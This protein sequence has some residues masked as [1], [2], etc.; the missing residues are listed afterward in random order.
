MSI[1]EVTEEP[2][3]KGFWCWDCRKFVSRFRTSF[4]QGYMA[5][6]DDDRV[7][8]RCPDCN[9]SLEEREDETL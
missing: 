5:N 3:L 2:Q 8:Y 7:S 4:K 1:G 9:S 6:G